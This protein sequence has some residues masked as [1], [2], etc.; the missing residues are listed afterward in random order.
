MSSDIRQ[1]AGGNARSK[2]RL[3]DAVDEDSRQIPTA[4]DSTSNPKRQR[5]SRACDSCRAK[6]SLSGQ[7]RWGST[8]ML[9][10]RLALAA[11]YIPSQSKEARPSDRI[12]PHAGIT[13]GASVQ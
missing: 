6:K 5:V 12:H 3:T 4:D 13:L 2:R 7:M 9:N 11:M 8:N 10:L 1:T